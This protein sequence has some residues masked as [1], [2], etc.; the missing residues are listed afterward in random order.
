M[1]KERGCRIRG[2]MNFR[3]QKHTKTGSKARVSSLGIAMALLIEGWA[4]CVAGQEVPGP[5][6]LTADPPNLDLG[7]IL[8]APVFE[9]PFIIQN[10]GILPIR[11]TDVGMNCE[12]C[13]S[14]HLDRDTLAPDEFAILDLQF[15]PA[16]LSGD[17][18][19]LVAIRTD[20][21]V[22]KPLVIPVAA[23][24]RPRFE[25]IGLPVKFQEMQE[26]EVRKWRV[27]VVPGVELPGPLTRAGSNSPFFRAEVDSVQ[28]RDSFMVTI[29]AG[30]FDVPGIHKGI[31][32]LEGEGGLECE[33]PVAAFKVPEFHYFPGR[34][35]VEPWDQEQFRILFIRQSGNPPVS[36]TGIR[37]PE[38]HV[39]YEIFQ[40]PGFPN[41]RINLYTSGLSETNGLVGYVE[42]DTD[43]AKPGMIQVPVYAQSLNGVPVEQT[44]LRGRVF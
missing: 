34:I 23:H 2:I 40:D 28:D 3:L 12:D 4:N 18:K 29:E 39:K 44:C 19:L 41:Y 42:I 9:Q 16:S 33:I 20:G 1:Y 36:I 35:V 11:I 17:I 24:V 6:Q 31:I 21:M 15:D 30:P 8:D 27:E 43:Q 26:E 22:S 32:R 13:A 14:Y 5:Y 25:M 38:K 10:T 37:V 7:V